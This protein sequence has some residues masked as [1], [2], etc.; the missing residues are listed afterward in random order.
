MESLALFLRTPTSMMAM[1][2]LSSQGKKVHLVVWTLHAPTQRCWELLA[3]TPN[4]LI[5]TLLL[6]HDSK[7]RATCRD[8]SVVSGSETNTFGR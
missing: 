8:R 2:V 4:T 3:M 7:W 6:R 5:F 1:L